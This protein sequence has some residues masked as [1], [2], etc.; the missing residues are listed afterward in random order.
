[1]AYSVIESFPLISGLMYYIHPSSPLRPLSSHCASIA[2]AAFGQPLWWVKMGWRPQM[3]IASADKGDRWS[4]VLYAAAARFD[5]FLPAPDSEVTFALSQFCLILFDLFSQANMATW[6]SYHSPCQD[7]Y[8]L[9]FSGLMSGGSVVDTSELTLP[10]LSSP[11][12]ARLITWHSARNQMTP[13]DVNLG[14]CIP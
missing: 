3:E 9:F 4:A 14:F 12:S 5:F 10:L 6:C 11:S 2:V 1:M 13:L 8:F 7:M